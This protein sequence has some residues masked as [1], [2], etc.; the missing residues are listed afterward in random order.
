MTEESILD[1]SDINFEI[2]KDSLSLTSSSPFISGSMCS[3][4]HSHALLISFK[5]SAAATIR[6]FGNSVL[7]GIIKTIRKVGGFTSKTFWTVDHRL[8][9]V[10]M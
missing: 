4:I 7:A 10:V 5:V 9:D 1:T 2:T 6:P 8:L 3:S